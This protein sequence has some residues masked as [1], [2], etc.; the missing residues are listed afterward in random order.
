MLRHDAYHRFR[1][2]LFAQDLKPGQFVTQRELSELME[3]PVGPLREALKRLEAEALVRLIPQRGIQIADV[4]VRMI[5]EAFHLR[6][7]LERE[8]FRRLAVLAPTVV[9][10]EL[11]AATQDVIDT[12]LSGDVSQRLR[13][14]ALAVDQSMHDTAIAALDNGLIS[15]VYRIN[16]DK[17]RLIRLN[18]TFTPDRVVPAMREHLSIIAACQ[19]RDPDAAVAALEHHLQTSERRSLGL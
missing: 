17:I 16:S 10:E 1:D 19:S 2:L 12:A 18:G 4:N 15:D 3:V 8:A 5:R 9:L 14:R 13:D 11:A 7:V 6:L